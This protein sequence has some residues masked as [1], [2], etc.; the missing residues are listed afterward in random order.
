MMLGWVLALSAADFPTDL[1]GPDSS[2]D[3]CTALLNIYNAFGGPGSRSCNDGHV[4]FDPWKGWLEGG[5]YCSWTGVECSLDTGTVR[6]LRV[7]S[8]CQTGT[9]YNAPYQIPEGIGRFVQIEELYLPVVHSSYGDEISIN[10]T[11]PEAFTNLTTLRVL[12]GPATL[13]AGELPETLG[14]MGS[15]SSLS[16]FMRQAAIS[17]TLPASISTMEGLADLELGSNR[18]SGTISA[19]L[20]SLPALQTLAITGASWT[21]PLPPLKFTSPYL[22]SVAV[23]APNITTSAVLDVTLPTGAQLNTL[24]VNATG[25]TSI[26]SGITKALDVRYMSAKYPSCTLFVPGLQATA[27]YTLGNGTKRACTVTYLMC[28]TT[29][30]PIGLNTGTDQWSGSNVPCTVIFHSKYPDSP[31][32]G[33]GGSNNCNYGTCTGP[34]NSTSKSIDRVVT[35]QSS[36]PKAIDNRT[37]IVGQYLPLWVNY[38]LKLIKAFMIG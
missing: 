34:D 8:S 23:T 7:P 25:A 13:L 29:A 31:G 4:G 35:D 6:A 21:G 19:G 22:R 28:N 3:D 38:G 11:I 15:L 2:A 5:S 30:C 10:G 18:V 16:W 12:G 9:P 26:A 1:C 17:G 33:C 36:T 20:F 14:R 37:T 24:M 27:T 32:Y